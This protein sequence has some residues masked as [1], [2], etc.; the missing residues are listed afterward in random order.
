MLFFPVKLGF[1]LKVFLNRLL[2]RQKEHIFHV[3]LA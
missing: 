3:F 1:Q 2:T